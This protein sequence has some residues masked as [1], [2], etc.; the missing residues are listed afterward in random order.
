[1]TGNQAVLAVAAALES[2]GIPYMLVG[3]YSSNFMG[4]IAR[5][6]MLIS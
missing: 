3:S 4:S 6:K 5:R 1:M 2:C